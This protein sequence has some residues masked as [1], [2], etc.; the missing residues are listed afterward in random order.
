MPAAR[1]VTQFCCSALRAELGL[2]SAIDVA[3]ATDS[4]MAYRP[5]HLIPTPAAYNLDPQRLLLRHS[6]IY[7]HLE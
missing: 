4:S 7:A 3:A 6:I 5:L 1:E 2:I